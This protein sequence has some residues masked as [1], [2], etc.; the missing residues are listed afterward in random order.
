MVDK[1]KMKKVMRQFTP[2]R[3]AIAKMGSEPLELPNYS[4][5]AHHSRERSEDFTINNLTLNGDL[6]TTHITGSVIFSDGTKLTEDNSNLYWDDTNKRLGIGTDSP[7]SELD[8]R[9]RVF[10]KAIG[11]GTT[12]FIGYTSTGLVNARLG[13][14]SADHAALALEDSSSAI[15]ILLRAAGN[16][17]FLG[18]DIGIGISSPLF[19]P[20]NIKSSADTFAG[21]ILL[22]DKDSATYYQGIALDSTNALGL[23]YY[24]GSAWVQGITLK[25]NGDVGINTAS[26][27]KLLTV[28]PTSAGDGIEVYESD[29]ELLATTMTSF[30]GG[31]ALVV[32]RLGSPHTVFNPTGTES[33]INEVGL[34]HDFRIESNNDANLFFTDGAEDNVGFGTNTPTTKLSVMEKS[35]MSPIGGFCIK[36]T[37]KTGANSVQGEVVRTDPATDDSVILAITAEVQAIGVFL[38]SGV[39]D[40]SEAWIVVSGIA[41][42]LADTAGF[43]RGD[44]LVTSITA[45]TVGRAT[46]NNAPSVAVHFQEIGHALE[47]AAGNALGRCVLHFN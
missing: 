8:V 43:T 12:A 9:G 45:A 11:T 2:K 30:S 26:P 14:W 35:G 39:S 40:G 27:N 4:G 15:K 3:T 6:N 7:A 19:A 38:E 47:T 41:D 5:A 24:T 20:L 33:V 34:N 1:A 10:A 13:S 21:G 17:Y 37:N 31:G 29:S 22:Q 44:R 36:L 18:G 32:Y 25:R 46:S 23:Y 42:V 16:S 28:N